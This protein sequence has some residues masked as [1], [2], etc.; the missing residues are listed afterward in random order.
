MLTVQGS[1]GAS[2]LN[3]LAIALTRL[4][5]VVDVSI[6]NKTGVVTVCIVPGM[7]H[8]ISKLQKTSLDAG[9]RILKAGE[10]TW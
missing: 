4:D 8:D 9:Y 5:F 1:S 2:D 10:I 6:V 7:T 3:N